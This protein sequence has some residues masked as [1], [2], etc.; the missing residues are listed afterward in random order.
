MQLTV[1]EL[2]EL[3]PQYK[4]LPAVARD[5]AVGV[6]ALTE[7]CRQLD[8]PVVKPG[9]ATGVRLVCVAELNRKLKEAAQ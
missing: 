2:Q 9:G 5:M 6:D 1:E 7:W 3:A 8:V 4:A